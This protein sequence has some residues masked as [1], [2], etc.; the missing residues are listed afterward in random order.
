MGLMTDTGR[1]L[2]IDWGM[3]NVGLAVSDPLSITAQP[4]PTL[5]RT[6]RRADM[7][8]IG[9]LVE[10]MQVKRILVG[11][12]LHLK[13]HAGKRAMEAERLAERL[14]ESTGLPVELIDERLTSAEADRLMLDAGLSRTK[15]REKADRIAAQLILQTYLDRQTVTG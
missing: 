15:R 11:H 9:E 14:R 2:A 4:L 7:A 6:N 1:I 5:K 8:R 10:A 3:K 13:G 12:P